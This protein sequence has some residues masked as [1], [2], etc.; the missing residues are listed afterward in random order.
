MRSRRTHMAFSYQSIIEAQYARIAEDHA[1]LTADLEAAR[2]SENAYAVTDAADKILAL[3]QQRAALDARASSFVASQ[4]Q[5]QGNKYG[6]SRDEQEI[7]H[8]ISSGDANLSNDQREA[9]YSHNRQ[10]LRHM[11]ATG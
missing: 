9:I 6:L 8:G 2:M 5:P 7:A 10:R 11:R 4:Q 3:D 1:Q